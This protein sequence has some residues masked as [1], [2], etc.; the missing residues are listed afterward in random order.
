MTVVQTRLQS[1]HC[2]STANLS[3]DVSGKDNIVADALSDVEPAPD[4][5]NH[6]LNEDL[7]DDTP[8]FLCFAIQQGMD[9]QVLANDQALDQDVQDYRTAIS[10]LDLADV[11]GAFT[12][13]C[14][15]TPS[16]R[17]IVPEGWRRKFFDTFHAL[18][19]P[20]ARTTLRLISNKFV[21]NK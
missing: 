9:Y 10:N 13:L 21:R 1:F 7:V 15:L 17:P 3:S 19:H 2:T 16:A 18:S 4:D 12:V 6:M 8:G 11:S 20:R 14:V 5:P